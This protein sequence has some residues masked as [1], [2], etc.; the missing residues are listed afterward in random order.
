VPWLHNDQ[1]TLDMV[2]AGTPLYGPS[3]KRLSPEVRKFIKSLLS[4]DPAKRPSAT[5]ALS[6]PWLKASGAVEPSTSVS[7]TVLQNIRDFAKTSSLQRCCATMTAWS[8]SREDQE[9]MRDHFLAFGMDESGSLTLRVFTQAMRFA[10]VEVAEAESLFRCLD[11]D[12]DGEIAFSEFIAGAS[13]PDNLSPDTLHLAFS[14]LD[15]DGDG[16]ITS[17][18]LKA[19]LGKSFLKKHN[20]EDWLLDVGDSDGEISSEMFSV[21]MRQSQRGPAE[22]NLA[23]GVRDT[24]VSDSRSVSLTSIQSQDAEKPIHKVQGFS[25]PAKQNGGK[26]LLG[27]PV[28]QAKSAHAHAAHGFSN[29]LCVC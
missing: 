28:Q 23:C 1:K 26:V 11:V 10:K 14:R 24:S 19:V 8:C 6:D 13:S 25:E 3:F 5:D 15:V 16:K 27:S 18:D 17:K 29:Q 22:V 9:R 21:F 4:K 20:V 7:S 2:K 12:G